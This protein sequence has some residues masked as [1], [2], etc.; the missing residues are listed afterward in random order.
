MNNIY[1]E[2]KSFITKFKNRTFLLMGNYINLTVDRS[3]LSE[4]NE[5]VIKVEN[6]HGKTNC[7]IGFQSDGKY[8]YHSEGKGNDVLT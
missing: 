4:S 3:M 6:I 5:L 1:V 2:N 8:Q 7:T